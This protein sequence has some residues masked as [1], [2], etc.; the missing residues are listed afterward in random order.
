MSAS[1]AR[2]ALWMTRMG[3]AGRGEGIARV[4]EEIRRTQAEALGRVGEALEQLRVADRA[5]DAVPE[6][7]LADPAAR[8]RVADLLVARNRLREEAARSGTT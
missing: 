6:S 1:G 4:E 7:N 3:S 5:L 2:E 8:Q